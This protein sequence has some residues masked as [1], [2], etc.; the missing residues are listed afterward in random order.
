MKADE[1]ARKSLESREL[2]VSQNKRIHRW[3]SKLAASPLSID[4]VDEEAKRARRAMM[5]EIRRRSHSSKEVEAE[6]MVHSA[7]LHSA[8]LERPDETALLREAKRELVFSSKQLRAMQDV[9][10]SNLRYFS[11][12]L[13]S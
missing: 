13:M 8:S 4:L 3:E 12:G 6:R 9:A 5:C 10:K 1:L 11:L 7:V 2:L